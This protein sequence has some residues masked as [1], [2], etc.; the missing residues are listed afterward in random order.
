MIDYSIHFDLEC[1]GIDNCSF[2]KP[3]L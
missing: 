2:K 3:N 1:W